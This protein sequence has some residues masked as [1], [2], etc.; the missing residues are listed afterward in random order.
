MASTL[1]GHFTTTGSIANMIVVDRAAAE[2][3]HFLGINRHPIGC[4]QARRV[5]HI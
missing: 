1:A 5:L 2:G 4:V 3:M